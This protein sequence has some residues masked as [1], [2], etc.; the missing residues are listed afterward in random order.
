[1]IPEVTLYQRAGCHLCEI[2]L[3]QLSE[4]KRVHDFELTQVDIESSDE[5]HALYL[6]RIPVIALGGVELYDFEI[7]RA[8]LESRLSAAAAR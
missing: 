6:E 8:D 4:I 1:M 3:A 5:L 7:D 2:A